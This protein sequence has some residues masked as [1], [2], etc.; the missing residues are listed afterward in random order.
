MHRTGKSRSESESPSASSLSLRFPTVKGKNDVT[1][2]SSFGG[3]GR[4][5]AEG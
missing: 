5:G 1:L 2:G 4:G 3:P